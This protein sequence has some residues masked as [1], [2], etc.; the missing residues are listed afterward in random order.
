MPNSENLRQYIIDVDVNIKQ[1]EEKLASLQSTIDEGVNTGKIK[2]DTKLATEEMAK[3]FEDLSKEIKKSVSDGFDGI[4]TKTLEKKF[5]E[6]NKSIETTKDQIDL[7]SKAL[8]DGDFGKFER[9][10]DAFTAPLGELNKTVREIHDSLQSLVEPISTI[11]SKMTAGITSG[12]EKLEEVSQKAT[13]GVNKG[14]KNFAKASGKDL[15]NFSNRLLE[16]ADNIDKILGNVGKEE[17]D[18]SSLFAGAKNLISDRDLDSAEQLLS[19][20]SSLKEE[21]KLV[22]KEAAA[23]KL[24]LNISE[25]LN[26]RGY[27]KLQFLQ[28]IPLI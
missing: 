19:I 7:L 11:S 18:R 2:K 16:L 12:M 25:I 22:E 15:E 10:V 20:V 5:K 27:I 13:K 8:N 23:K 17:S 4:N 1:A 21:I 28:F 14:F 24:N 3:M 6:F 9:F 26:L